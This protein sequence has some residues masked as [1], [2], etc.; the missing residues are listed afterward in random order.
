MQVIEVNLLITHVKKLG[1]G[2][3]KWLIQSTSLYYWQRQSKPLYLDSRE[4]LFL[5]YCVPL[6][7]ICVSHNSE[8]ASLI[9]WDSFHVSFIFNCSSKFLNLSEACSFLL[10]EDT[11][12]LTPFQIP[13][14]HISL[15]CRIP[16]TYSEC[17]LS[18]F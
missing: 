17:S 18:K 8:V 5:Q 11:L 9:S 2:L 6:Q 12:L 16:V 13:Y 15:I 10:S 4:G 7:K 14:T 1:L 3:I